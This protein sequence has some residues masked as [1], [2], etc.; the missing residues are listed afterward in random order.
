VF[1]FTAGFMAA[2]SSPSSPQ[3][4]RARILGEAFAS[5]GCPGWNY[6]WS[7]MALLWLCNFAR[8]YC[9][10]HSFSIQTV[11]YEQSEVLESLGKNMLAQK[12]LF[13]G[14]RQCDSL[15]Q[16]HQSRHTLY[17]SDNEVNDRHSQH[18]GRHS[19]DEAVSTCDLIL[20]STCS[21]LPLS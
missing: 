16:L 6:M 9:T 14:N 20:L 1:T 7:Q 3:A 19:R 5:V 18:C 4:G 10:T 21:I 17:R 8:C 15:R 12:T 13:A 2:P 11:I